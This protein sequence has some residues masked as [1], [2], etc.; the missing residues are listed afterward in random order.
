VTYVFDEPSIGLHDSE[1][2]KLLEV[3]HSLVENGNSLIVVEHDEKT[4]RTA[5]HLIDIGPDAGTQGGELVFCDTIEELLN[6]AN[7]IDNSHTQNW[8]SGRDNISSKKLPLSKMHQ[9][10]T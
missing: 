10:I 5:D 9:E 7:E 1:Q 8:L 3:L 6:P 2:D 4:I